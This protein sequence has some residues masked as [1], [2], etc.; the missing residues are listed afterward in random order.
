MF[1]P[2]SVTNIRRN[3]GLRDRSQR[4]CERELLTIDEIAEQLTIAGWV[5]KDWRDKGLLQAHRYDDKGQCHYEPPSHD[6]PGKFKKSD[7]ARWRRQ[8]ASHLP[9]R[10]SMKSKLL[11]RNS[12]P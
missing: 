3:Y 2:M 6:L 7:R 12:A 9:T 5:V 11:E 1:T 10:C 8:P 4:S